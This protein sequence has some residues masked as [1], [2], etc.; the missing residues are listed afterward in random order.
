M[1]LG[2]LG[3]VEAQAR[4]DRSPHRVGHVSHDGVRLHYLSWGTAGSVIVLLPGFT[5]TAHAF[6]DIGPRLAVEHRVIAL[7][8]RGFGESD[9]PDDASGYTI[10]TLVED[11]HVL[12]DTLHVTRAALV[13]HSLSGTVAAHFALRFPERVS[14]LI[15]LDAFPY[16]AAAGGDSVAALDP[17]ETPPF[18]GDT[19][20]D[21]AAVYLGRYRYVPW[22]RALDADLRVKPLGQEAARRRTLTT[23]YIEDQPRHPPDLSQLTVPAVEVC[24]VASVGSEYPWLQRSAAQFAAAQAYVTQHLVPF[25][26]RLCQRFRDTVPGGRTE[27]LAGSHYVFF[28]QPDRTVQVV[29][30]FLTRNR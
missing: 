9:A 17:V 11:L 1:M 14:H 5:L 18:Q 28:T 19:T 25:N 6:D 2:P 29:R 3:A 24:A 23:H 20:Y 10:S 27:H 16:F 21:A 22:R 26:R 12:L 13:A 4:R 15:L 30:R 8:P 7:T